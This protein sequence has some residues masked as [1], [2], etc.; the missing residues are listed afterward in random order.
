[1]KQRLLT[2]AIG[3]SVAVAWLFTMYTPFFAVIMVFFTVTAEYEMLKV[4]EVKNIP[5]KVLCMLCSAGI[6][7][8]SDWKQKFQLPLFPVI[9][10]ILIL[11]FILMVLDFKKL[12]FEQ[13]VCSLFASFASASALSCSVL[14]RDVYLAFPGSFIKKDGIFFL[15][16]AFFCSWVTDGCALFAGVAFGKHKLAP[17]ISPKKTVEGAVGGVIG[18]TLLCVALYYVFRL[19]VGLSDS[20]GLV[21]VIVSA[22]VLSVLSIFGDL[23]ASTIKRHH[24]I[25]DFGNL[26][27]GHGGVMDRFDSC[28]F[29]FPAL[30][31]IITV[32]QAI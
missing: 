17:E 11:S 9:T 20:I 22:L 19:K 2:A 24:G 4:F 18:N 10:G 1:M 23:A 31:G 30:Y 3:L 27:P 6:M 32:M 14:F 12:K 5:F 16:F 13:V 15:L 26:L 21:F 29:V 7:L 8:Y 25:K 28:I